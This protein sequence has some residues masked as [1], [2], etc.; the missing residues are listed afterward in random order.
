LSS[1][2]GLAAWCAVTV[3]P[4]V[5]AGAFV[6]FDPLGIFIA[7]FGITAPISIF[8][9]CHIIMSRL[10]RSEKYTLIVAIGV[11]AAYICLVHL[12]WWDDRLYFGVY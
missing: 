4:L 12:P 3:L 7:F 9:A 10:K 11:A 8:G 5:A 1:R 6:R 2:Y